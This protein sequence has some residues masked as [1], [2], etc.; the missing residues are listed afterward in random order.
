MRD[1]IGRTL[2]HYRIVDKIGEGGMGQVYRARDE[3][4]GR[5][6]AV[7]VLPESVADDSG[8]LARFR[9]EAKLLGQ[10]SHNNIATLFGLEVEGDTPYL[11]MELVEG[12]TL[13]SQ[14]SHGPLPVVDALAVAL[15]LAEALEAAHEQGI[16]HRDLKP[17][18]IA[19]TEDLHLKVLD[20]GLATV[21][22]PQSMES[23]PDESPT[24][25][26]ATQAGTILG[27]AAYM[28]PEQARGKQVDKRTDIWAFGCCVFEALAGQRPFSGETISDTLVELLER[29]P[30]WEAL[31]DDTPA[32]IRTL[33]RRCLDKDRR[34][35]LR[36]IGEARVAIADGARWATGAEAEVVLP[37]P[38]SW[39]SRLAFGLGVAAVSGVI[40]GSAVWWATQPPALRLTRL[41][42]TAPSRVLPEIAI[43]PDGTKVVYVS[44]DGTG[45][46]VRAL[47]E[48]EPR[49]LPDLGSPSQPFISPDGSWIGFFDGLKSLMKVPMTGG[50]A[51]LVCS[52]GGTAPRGASWA[53]DGAIIF[54]TDDPRTGLW[55]VPDSGGEP[56]MLNTPELGVEEHY[57]PHVLPG[58]RAVLLTI[59]QLG[60][61]VEPQVGLLDLDSGTVR[62]LFPGC[63]P[64]YLSTGHIIFGISGKMRAV[65]FD[66]GRCE[67]RGTS[68]PVL[69]HVATNRRGLM[70]VAVADD[71]TLAYLPGGV[72]G[73]SRQL[74]W[75]D[76]QGNEEPLAAPP[77]A[78][79]IPR[80]S[81]DGTRVALDNRE[82]VANIWIWDIERQAMTRFTF[83]TAAYPV[84][85]P[86]GR[87][88]IYTS[89]EEGIG[90]L[91]WRASD[92]SA[93]EERLLVGETNRY[94]T[95]MA[96]DGTR[97]VFREEGGQTGV[98]IYALALGSDRP[99]EPLIV[100]DFNELNAEISPDGRWLA[101]R[102]NQSGQ[103]EV[104][105][106]PFPD[107]AAGL[108][109]ISTEGGE[110][111]LWAR[112]GSEIFYRGLD[113]S[114]LQV[115]VELEPLF[116]AATPTRIFKGQYLR[117]YGRAYDVSPDGNRFLMIKE[118][119]N[120]SDE[121]SHLGIVVVQNWF[122]ELRRLVPVD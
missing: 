106:R 77:G 56:E 5:D 44:A 98:D 105:V 68:T 122:E 37:T 57:W 58:A 80:I 27:T 13:A 54:A 67:V 95:S 74:V 70:G 86:D 6:V 50:A 81:P 99:P 104:Y 38:I 63:H 109:Q 47:D 34:R 9:R 19:L 88:L 90:R 43:S 108:W 64:M 33:L 72:L 1:L 21:L 55:R 113:G 94:P 119:E 79:M 59:F 4:L 96:P 8:R 22:A 12:E 26:L 42:I 101:Y 35:R 87:R 76:R 62:S 121:S 53:D 110:H 46:L 40:V 92:G 10:L 51:E 14:L 89:F 48:L 36:D 29:E 31:P 111:P 25:S 82:P 49:L 39:A 93:M 85:T 91:S 71:G 52:V 117:G 102:S 116:S 120:Q 66:P 20:F 16:V 118:G 73:V 32:V 17:S 2:G 23:D 3:L 97:L 28:S 83:G 30:D 114:V 61:N 100:T 103:D 112:D 115:P 69:E 45:L 65:G 18:N 7:K 78:Y 15:Q 60:L 41:S 24:L 11:A 107:V 75:V 84:W